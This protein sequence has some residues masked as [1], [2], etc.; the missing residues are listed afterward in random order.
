MSRL[1][2]DAYLLTHAADIAQMTGFSGHD[3][4]ALVTHRSIIVV[5]DSRYTEELSLA[6]PYATLVLRKQSMAESLCQAIARTRS[7][8][9]GFETNFVT[10]GL[11]DGL[12]RALRRAGA[13]VALV[14]VTDRLVTLRK[15]KDADEISAIR[16]AILIAEQAFLDV[17]G[18]FK[19]DVSES[20]LTGELILAM[21]SRGASDAAF[22]P[23]IA[24]GAH[25]SLPH[26]RPDTTPS[27][28]R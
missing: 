7:A 3:S 13:S 6:A 23:I 27:T 20:Q 8:R 26:Y 10:F 14:P 2:L 24:S 21:R 19:P 25:S 9:I 17:I 5:T 28:L 4:T 11:I 15:N 1:K 18:K 22:Q 16:Q 12:K